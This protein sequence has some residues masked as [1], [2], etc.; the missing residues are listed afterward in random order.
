MT[1][2]ETPTAKCFHFTS[3]FLSLSE[4]EDSELL[5]F[6]DRDLFIKMIEFGIERGYVSSPAPRTELSEKVDQI[7]YKKIRE[8]I[9]K[10]FSGV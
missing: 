9:E 4:T 8:D 7:V 5:C 10:D 3:R 2:K 6:I 1:E